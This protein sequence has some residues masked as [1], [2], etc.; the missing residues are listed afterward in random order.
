MINI[1]DKFAEEIKTCVLC[2]I[3]FVPETLLDAIMWKNIE[4]SDRPQTTT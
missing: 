1:S 4:E 3:T 2:S